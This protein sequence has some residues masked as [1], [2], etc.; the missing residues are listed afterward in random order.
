MY[1]YSFQTF[2][3]KPL[4]RGTMTMGRRNSL[5]KLVAVRYLCIIFL[6]FVARNCIKI[7]GSKTPIPSLSCL[8]K[9]KWKGRE[10]VLVSYLH[11]PG[12]HQQPNWK[13]RKELFIPFLAPHPC[14]QVQPTQLVFANP[15]RGQW[16]QRKKCRVPEIGLTLPYRAKNSLG[17][18]NGG[19]ELRSVGKQSICHVVHC[20]EWA[21]KN[22]PQWRDGLGILHLLLNI[23][24]RP[25]WKTGSSS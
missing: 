12:M 11:C 18:S 21:V 6:S 13:A 4:R 3:E 25:L 14:S 24:V 5:C 17:G 20:D 7:K 15:F 19:H 10:G 22:V 16:V 2:Q 8:Q 1:P 9:Q 23:L